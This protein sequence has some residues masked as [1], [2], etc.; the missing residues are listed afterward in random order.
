[1][2]L[3]HLQPVNIVST[4]RFMKD[5]TTRGTTPCYIKVLSKHFLV[6]RNGHEIQ[7]ENEFWIKTTFRIEVAINKMYINNWKAISA[8]I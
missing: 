8:M 5:S 2:Y 6:F 4:S 3:A 1:M 7:V